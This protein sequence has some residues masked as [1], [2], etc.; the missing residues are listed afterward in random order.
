MVGLGSG[1]FVIIVSTPGPVLNLKLP[2]RA[3]KKF[4]VGWGGLFDYS[5]YSWPS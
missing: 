4:V 1:L 3:L 5:V 2:S